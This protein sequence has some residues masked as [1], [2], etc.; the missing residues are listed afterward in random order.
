DPIPNKTTFVS[1]SQTPPCTTTGTPVT[2]VSWTIPSVGPG[3]PVVVTFQVKLDSSFPSGTTTITNVGKVCTSEEGCKN[4]PPTTVTV[5]AAP[6][7]GVVKTAN[8]AGPVNAGVD[9][10]YSLA[11]SN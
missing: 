4:S 2:S 7:L 9:I 10:T 3:A 1:C 5:T 8:T 6:K 11:Y